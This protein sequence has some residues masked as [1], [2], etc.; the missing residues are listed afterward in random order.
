MGL[1]H[2]VN[3]YTYH[4]SSEASK[5]GVLRIT[6]RLLSRKNDTISF[7]VWP[8]VSGTTSPD[9][10]HFGS[11]FWMGIEEYLWST[12]SRDAQS[13]LWRIARP[14]RFSELQ[15]WREF[16]FN[17][18]PILWFTA[19]IH[20]FSYSSAAA[21]FFPGFRLFCFSSRRLTYSKRS[22]NSG[23]PRLANGNPMIAT[24]RA[25][26]SAKFKP[27]D[28]FA[29][30]TANNKAPF[31]SVGYIKS[32]WNNVLSSEEFLFTFVAAAAYCCRTCST[33]PSSG[34]KKTWTL[35]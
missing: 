10:I 8:N 22:R 16:I 18:L 20:M 9:S 31:P 24:P 19:F 4:N 35:S 17:Y 32:K 25:R 2:A 7:T 14:A 26:S 30:M 3:W 23:E 15:E 13:P 1:L 28:S 5:H 33:E 11:L 27:S 21:S 12:R 6:Y 34:S 29:P